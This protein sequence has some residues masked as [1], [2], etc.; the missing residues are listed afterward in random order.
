MTTS[1]R[2]AFLITFYTDNSCTT[3]YTGDEATSTYSVS[4]IR[5][6]SYDSSQPNN[7][8]FVATCLAS[9]LHR[10]YMNTA[11][12]FIE[13]IEIPGD[14]N[15]IYSVGAYLDLSTNVD[16]LLVNDAGLWQPSEGDPATSPFYISTSLSNDDA[17]TGVC[18]SPAPTL[19]PTSSAPTRDTT[20]A[21]KLGR[22][23]GYAAFVS[24]I[25]LFSVLGGMYMAGL[26][27][28]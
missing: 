2:L 14:F 25:V 23:N 10:T 28:D 21:D 16:C 19:S 12:A 9:G 5:S 6:G 3:F 22:P 20:Y 4:T 17:Y 11:P 24:L 1:L 8:T 7:R 13:D 15:T 18:P 27:I 26:S